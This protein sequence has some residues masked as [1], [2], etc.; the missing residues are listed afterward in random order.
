VASN[1]DTLR[2]LLALPPTAPRAADG[3]AERAA[4]VFRMDLNAGGASVRDGIAVYALALMMQSREGTR[5][6]R[7]LLNRIRD[8]LEFIEPLGWIE[9][10]LQFEDD[11]TPVLPFS[12]GALEPTP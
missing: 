11:G 5:E 1:L 12:I 4:A 3:D 9:V 10:A 6:T 7:V 8:A 2:A